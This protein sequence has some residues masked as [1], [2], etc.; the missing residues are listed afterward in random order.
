MTKQSYIGVITFNV[1]LLIGCTIAKKNFCGK[2]YMNN[3]RFTYVSDEGLTSKYFLIKDTMQLE[4]SGDKLYSQSTIKW[5]SCNDYIL[6]IKRIYYTEAGLQPGD[7]LSVKL[8]SFKNDTLICNATAYN[9]SFT[10]KLLK[11]NR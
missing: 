10:F 5:S 7:T 9:H 4:Y 11:S 8:Q 3:Q 1:L 2:G 6:I